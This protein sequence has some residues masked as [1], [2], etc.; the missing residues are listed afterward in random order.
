MSS[1]FNKSRKLEGIPDI[2][3]IIQGGPSP[4]HGSYESN[5]NEAGT[6]HKKQPV[7][8]EEGSLIGDVQFLSTLAA[9]PPTT[10][11][12]HAQLTLGNIVVNKDFTH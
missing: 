8:G 12:F 6:E 7:V 3:R 5:N 11:Q 10:L 1:S 9:A 4:V 2:R